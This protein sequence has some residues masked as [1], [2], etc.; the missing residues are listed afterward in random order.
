MTTRFLE[1]FVA[2]E[3]QEAG[4]R[5]DAEVPRGLDRDGVK[6]F[7]AM[8]LR[9]MRKN[10]AFETWCPHAVVV[11]RTMVGHAGFHGPPGVNAYERE[12]AVE[13]GYAIEPEY[14]GRGYATAAARELIRIA[15]ARGVTH[16]F[17]SCAPGNEPSLAIIRKLGFVQTGEVVDEEDGPELVFERNA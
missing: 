5:L 6:G 14:R 3:L 2:G 13:I 11:G 7:F 16:V 4:A 17:A 9:Q 1:A 15:E 12:G 10:P 8:R